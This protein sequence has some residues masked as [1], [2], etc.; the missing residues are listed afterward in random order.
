MAR[1]SLSLAPNSQ[2]A[3]ISHTSLLCCEACYLT[4]HNSHV[5]Y[6]ESPDVGISIT[7]TCTLP[8]CVYYHLVTA[9][10]FQ[11][12]SHL[13]RYYLL[14]CLKMWRVTMSMTF[15][16]L[17]EDM[18]GHCLLWPV[19]DTL[20]ICHKNPSFHGFVQSI[21][22]NIVYYTYSRTQLYFTYLYSKNITTCFGPICGASSGCDLIK[23]T[24][25][26]NNKEFCVSHIQSNTTTFYVFV[27]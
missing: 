25:Q 23:N 9:F 27:Q 24:K 13:K 2:K 5:F 8:I 12:S 21:T 6:M 15:N 1:E 18:S 11:S 19:Q 3:T 16:L 26:N 17:C 20:V 7:I 4:R 14:V 10:H 22:K